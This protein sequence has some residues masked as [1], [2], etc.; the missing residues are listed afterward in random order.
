MTNRNFEDTPDSLSALRNSA[1]SADRVNRTHRV[2]RERAKT[3]AE[4]RAKIRSLWLPVAIFSAVLV[5]VCIAV[6][7]VLD[8]YEI[9][10]AGSQVA[11][12]QVL[13][14]LLWSIPVS[15]ALLAVVWFRQPRSETGK[16]GSY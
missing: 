7:M 8:E 9:V 15:A 5:A 16:R 6:W 11:S 3:L 4:R 14:P 1:A 13:V 12:Y 10:A 2:V